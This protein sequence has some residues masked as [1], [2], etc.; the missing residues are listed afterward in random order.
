MRRTSRRSSS[1]S[2]RST[3]TDNGK[4]TLRGFRVTNIVS[5]KLRDIDKTSKVVD[6]AVDRRRQRR[7]DPGHR[8]HDRQ[9]GRAQDA[10][11]R[12]RRRRREGAG[13]R[14]WRTA[15]GVGVGDPI[16]ITEGGVQPAAVLR[17]RGPR[18]LPSTAAGA[19]AD[20]AGRARRR[21]RASPSLGASS[22]GTRPTATRRAR[23]S[24]RPLACPC[25]PSARSA[26]AVPRSRCLPSRYNGAADDARFQATGSDG[27]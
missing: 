4:Q 16:N 11:A 25:G 21:H 27:N 2:S 18:A 12:G 22:S 7:A 5:A 23:R 3:T 14:R 24:G 13:A 17:R 19:D 26:A 6:D 20:R 9:A 15:S 10:G 1:A 8:V